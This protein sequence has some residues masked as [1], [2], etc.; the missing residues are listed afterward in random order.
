MKLRYSLILLFISITFLLPAQRIELISGE[1]GM[2]ATAHPLATKAAIDIM[3]K[4]GNAID[5]AVAA[6]FVIGVVE[7]DGS[8]LGGGGGMVIY[9]NEKKQSHYINYYPTAPSALPENFVAK[10]DRHTGRSVCIP[11]TVAGLTLA[12]E[13]FGKLAL[14]EIVQ[15]A[16]NHARDGFIIDET[17]ASLILDH[18]EI[19]AY[20]SAT[21]SIYLVDDFPKM[22]GDLI[23]QEAL[24]LTL[25]EIGEKGR[26]GFYKGKI[27]QALANGIKQRGG[28]ISLKDIESYQAEISE[29]LTGTYRDYKILSAGVPQSGISI[30]EGLNI[31]ENVKMNELGHYTENAQ[32]LHIMA[33]TFRKIYTDRHYYLG[34]KAFFNVPV[35][36]LLSK[37]YARE[38][39]DA[40]N[41]QYPEPKSYRDTETGMPRKYE[42][43]K[44]TPEKY[45]TFSDESFGFN[46]ANSTLAFNAEEYY[47]STTHLCVADA[48]GNAVSLTQTLGTF[49]GSGQTINGIL[50]N[51]ALT[52]F[53]ISNQESPNYIMANKQPR[54]TIAPTIVLKDEKPYL[55]IGSPGG[56][57][58]IAA[59]IQV[60]VN[61]IDFEMN[62]EEAN[63]AP[64]FYT[65]KFED[66]LHV[67]SGVGQN[68]IDKLN[69]MGHS[70]QV[71]EGTDLFF[72]G[73][74]MIISDPETNTYFGSADIRRG[75]NA[76]G[77]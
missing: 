47:G 34:D 21:A 63:R 44:I 39:F 62:A 12:H 41:Q 60:L 22:E 25:K 9:L 29:P 36:G 38:R 7:P 59:L 64:R 13:K 61:V 57:R 6:A 43:N 31:L 67:E 33:E 11:G 49:F 48:D 77:Y 35:Y 68:I 5:A 24:A 27:A 58:I 53:T 75:G 46:Q 15:P 73:V 70:V 65:Q 16:I 69:E 10:E 3:K 37:E 2:A 19:L 30:I 52:N 26:S 54:S 66:H 18:S 74:Q 42:D 55:I 32:T 51:C 20:D 45:C 56:R 8:G 28:T 4:G 71:Y 17:L 40:I 76:M 50:L 14:S 1:K 23:V 72:G